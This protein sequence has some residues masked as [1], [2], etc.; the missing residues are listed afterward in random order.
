MKRNGANIITKVRFKMVLLMLM[1]CMILISSPNSYWVNMP[2]KQAIEEIEIKELGPGE[3]EIVGIVRDK[4]YDYP[5]DN[6]RGYDCLEV[7]IKVNVGEEGVYYL[8]SR[9]YSIDDI[10]ITAFGDLCGF[11][12]AIFDTDVKLTK[13]VNVVPIYFPGTH[14]HRGKIN[15]P[16]K[17]K[18]VMVGRYPNPTET[19]EQNTKSLDDKEFYTSYFKYSQFSK[20]YPD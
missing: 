19:L 12:T 17:V 14:I 8:Y 4:G 15:G 1:I 10:C 2:P 16:Y 7:D 13:G 3:G 6:E 9:L 18:I 5:E 20:G 11:E